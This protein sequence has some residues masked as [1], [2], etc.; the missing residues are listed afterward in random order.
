MLE[1]VR[2]CI[3]IKERIMKLV[4]DVEE[5]KL[6]WMEIKKRVE[7]VVLLYE[8]VRKFPILRVKKL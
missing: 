4:D 8:G 5:E 2:A 3:D 7:E 6:L 1:S